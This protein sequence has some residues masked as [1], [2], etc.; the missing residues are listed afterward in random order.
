VFINFSLH[1]VA[2]SRRWICSPTVV[3]REIF[4]FWD[5]R[6]LLLRLAFFRLLCL[7][8]NLGF[9]VGGVGFLWVCWGVL[10]ST[11]PFSRPFFFPIWFFCLPVTAGAAQSVYLCPFPRYLFFFDVF[12]VFSDFPWLFL[13]IKPLPFPRFGE[14]MELRLKPSTL[15][16]GGVQHIEQFSCFPCQTEFGRRLIIWFYRILFS[17]T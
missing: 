15:L 2:G 3:V 7:W 5:L 12:A 4:C 11:F 14:C 17:N 10:F 9:W 16:A 6:V 8:T 1:L 13:R